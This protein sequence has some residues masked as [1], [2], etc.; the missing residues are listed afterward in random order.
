ME[1]MNQTTDQKADEQVPAITPEMASAVVAEACYRDP[2]FY[3]RIRADVR[4]TVAQCSKEPVSDAVRVETVQN[5][6]EV[7]HLVVP[8][9]RL[10]NEAGVELMSRLTDEEM[11][12]IAGGEL[13]FF[14]FGVGVVFSVAGAAAAA[15][16]SV[17]LA[18]AIGIATAIGV[19]AGIAAAIALPV[20]GASVYAGITLSKSGGRAAAVRGAADVGLS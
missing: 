9:G 12:D 16:V 6:P 1:S 2:E 15:N 18:T 17:G 19:V 11:K 4:G 14:T 3:R 8:N 20:I 5:T 7:V 13:V 10:A